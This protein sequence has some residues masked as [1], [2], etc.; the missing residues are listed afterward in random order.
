VQAIAREITRW[1]RESL[2]ARSGEV[3]LP[4]SPAP[5]G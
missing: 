3:A 5:G 2:V 4:D 1:R